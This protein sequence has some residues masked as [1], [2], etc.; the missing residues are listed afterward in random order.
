MTQLAG[1]RE[2]SSSNGRNE[3]EERVRDKTEVVGQLGTE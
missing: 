1:E 2:C 3:D